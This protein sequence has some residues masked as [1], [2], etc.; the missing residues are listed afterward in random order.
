MLLSHF[1]RELDF[2]NRQIYFIIFDPFFFLIY[3]MQS[4]VALLFV[5][6]FA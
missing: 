6:K 5:L 3:D 2:M 4:K 1:A